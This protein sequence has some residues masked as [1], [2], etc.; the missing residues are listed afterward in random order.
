MGAEDR[1][2]VYRRAVVATGT[3]TRMAAVMTRTTGTRIRRA[4]YWVLEGF[5]CYIINHSSWHGKRLSQ[6]ATRLAYVA[7]HTLLCFFLYFSLLEQAASGVCF[8]ANLADMD[9][10]RIGTWLF[11]IEFWR[12]GVRWDLHFRGGVGGYRLKLL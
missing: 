3:R 7:A 1:A 4:K 9:R 2:A 11:G 6:L 10:G 8:W 12:F 5:Y